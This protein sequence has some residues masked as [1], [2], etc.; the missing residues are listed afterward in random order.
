MTLLGTVPRHRR[1][2]H[3]PANPE[4]DEKHQHRQAQTNRGP[5][6]GDA[7]STRYQDTCGEE[8][9]CNPGQPGANAMIRRYAAWTVGIWSD[10][11][12]GIVR[13]IGGMRLRC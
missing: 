3:G 7:A 4:R 5:D 13:S 11:A 1:Q 2:Q 10:W 6:Q 9:Q 12:I 8:D